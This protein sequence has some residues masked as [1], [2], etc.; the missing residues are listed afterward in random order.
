MCR[1]A[2]A[3][4]TRRELRGRRALSQVRGGALACGRGLLQGSVLP[5]DALTD[6]L[7]DTGGC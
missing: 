4:L 2:G 3:L 5:G 1:R 6:G 7:A